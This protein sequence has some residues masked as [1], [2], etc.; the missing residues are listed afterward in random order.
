[1]GTSDRRPLGGRV[2]WV[3]GSSRGLGR[4]IAAHLAS[5]GARVAVHGTTPESTRAFNEAESLAAVAHAIA[6]EHDTET[7][8]VHAD[9][10]QAE[11]V[12]AALRQVHTAF[13]R[14]DIL[15]HA[16]GGDIGAAGTG[17]PNAGKPPNNDAIFISLEDLHAVLD[18]NLL[19]C[20]LVCRAVA[21]EMM[22]R[23]RGHIVTIGS[24]DGLHGTSTS[25]IYAT[26]KAGL[27]EYS[28]CLAARVREFNVHVNVIAPGSIVTARFRASRTVDPARLV[29]DGTLDRYGQPIEVARAV[30]FLVGQGGSF[31]SG[32]VLR[33]DGGM[34]LWPA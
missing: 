8:A 19:S 14:V 24:I 9:L 27:T 22:E 18:R 10:S 11:A 32:Q 13:G 28:R 26:A 1:M 17:G 16:A 20:I 15:V 23:R 2:A 12:D 31:V 33:V 6:D 30:E 21:P 4:V 34:Q 29:E 5:L 25:A 7:V 3:T